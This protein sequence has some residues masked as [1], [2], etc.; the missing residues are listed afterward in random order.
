MKYRF[1]CAIHYLQLEKEELTIKL[2]FG[3]ISNKRNVLENTF[4]NDLSLNTIGLHSIDK[5]N[6]AL[7]YHFVD[8]DYGDEVTQKDVDAY[9]T[10]FCFALLRQIQYYVGKL[11]SLRDNCIY[12][13]DGFLYT[14]TNRIADGCTFKASVSLMNTFAA[15]QYNA[16]IFTEKELIAQAIDLP[17][18]LIDDVYKGT[19][20]Y[21]NATQ[22]QHYKSSE[23]SRK[24]LA[25]VYV[26]MARKEA[27]VPMK[28]LMYCSAMEALV[29]SSTMEIS[30]QVAERVALLI[31]QNKDERC[32]IYSDIKKGYDTRSKIAH[33][34]YLK[35]NESIIE[36]EAKKLDNYLRQILQ[37]E[38]PFQLKKDDIDIYYL[39]KIMN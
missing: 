12:V 21:K 30:H 8:G 22:F 15:G 27:I 20:I 36:E 3:Y 26:A 14:Y 32:Q 10:T 28:I 17:N 33:G 16:T 37:L 9:G 38:E 4:N 6:D 39:N 35:K 25:A 24:E 23:L 11:W 18:F 31:G 13:R 7:S 2:P 5:V 29:A 34:D 19:A 1:I